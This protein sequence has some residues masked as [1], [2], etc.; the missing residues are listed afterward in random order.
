[1]CLAERE[2]TTNRAVLSDSGLGG[3][4]EVWNIILIQLEGLSGE[5]TRTDEC[6]LTDHSGCCVKERFLMGKQERH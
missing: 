3:H 4:N 6:F 5:V 1:M 2:V